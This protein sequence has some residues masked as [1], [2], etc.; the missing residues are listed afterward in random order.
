[1]LL[2]DDSSQNYYLPVSPRCIVIYTHEGVIVGI[3]A[4]LA[5]VRTGCILFGG[6]S[7]G[8]FCLFFLYLGLFLD[9]VDEL[10]RSSNLFVCSGHAAPSVTSLASEVDLGPRVCLEFFD[11]CT[12]STNDTTLEVVS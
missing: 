2:D 3:C 11:C 10:L 12:T 8:G 4:Y 1:M 6:F 9:I 5:S 7:T